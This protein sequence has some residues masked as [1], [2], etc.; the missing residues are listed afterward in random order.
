MQLSYCLTL[1]TVVIPAK[2]GIQNS[3]KLLDFGLRRNDCEKT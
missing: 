3:L 1:R 2:A